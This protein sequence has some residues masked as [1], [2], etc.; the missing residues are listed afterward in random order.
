MRQSC[1]KVHQCGHPC[2]GFANEGRC[3]PCL[4]LDCIKNHNLTYPQF[5]LLETQHA[6]EYCGICMVAGLGDEPSIMLGCKHIFHV[7]CILTKVSKRWPSP[8]MTFDFMN[9]SQCKQLMTFP[10]PHP[11]IDRHW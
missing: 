5:Q 4:N 11:E 7:R 9:C 6:E 1:N 3:L 8:R 2:K 10:N